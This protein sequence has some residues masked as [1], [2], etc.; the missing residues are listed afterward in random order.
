MNAQPDA[1]KRKRFLWGVLLA[2][3]PFL[4]LILPI[5]VAFVSSLSSQKATGL[6]AVAGG[7]SEAMVT[8]GLAVTLAFELIAIVL[9]LRAFSRG[10]PLRA[11]FSVLSICCSGIVLFGFGFFLWLYLRFAHR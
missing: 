6:G 4:F 2:W 1:I 7:L 10:H 5:A 11:F 3:I 9:L 8:F